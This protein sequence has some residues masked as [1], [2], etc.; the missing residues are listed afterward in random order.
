MSEHLPDTN[1]LD[2]EMLQRLGDLELI[3][4]EVVEGLRVG[5]HRSNLKGFSTE[6]A[7]HRQYSPGDALRTIDWR[8]FGRT[9]RY[10]TKLYEAETNFDCHLLVDASASMNYGSGK[11]SKLEY[12]K[13]LSASLAYLVLKQ[14]DSVGLSVFDSEVRAYLPPRSAMGIILE[15]DRLLKG[16]KTTPKTSL[17]KQLHDVALMMKRR[18]VVVVISDFLSDV[19]D[20]LGGLD[21]L[22]FDGH[23]VIV[24]HTLDPY[25]LEFP[26]DGTWRFEGLEGEEPL[27]TQPQ[28]IRD[29]YLA[30]MG[31]YMESLRAGCVAAQIDYAV[32]DTSR[33]LDV[34]L[35]EFINERQTTL[36][37]GAP[38]ARS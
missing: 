13:Y 38:A 24:L 18:S 5:S 31:E 1:Y 4:R 21:H 20:I 30:S 22:R 9:D 33:P 32:V 8:V 19:E 2:S 3:A 28:R 36:G 14:R 23:N 6:F 16:V 17:A 26:F 37:G 11:V 15:I 25:E 7:H 34:F 10:Y 27:T 29:D 12:A 35:S